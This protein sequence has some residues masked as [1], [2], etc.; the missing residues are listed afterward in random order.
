[1]ICYQ[2]LAT[3]GRRVGQQEDLE[4]GPFLREIVFIQIKITVH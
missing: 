3:D 4:K 1:M 2:L